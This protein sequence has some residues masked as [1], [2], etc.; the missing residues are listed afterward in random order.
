V[1]GTWP[2]GAVDARLGPNLLQAQQ[3][4][5]IT[6]VDNAG[7]YPGSPYFKIT[8]AGTERA[9]AATADAE[10][11]IVPLFTGESE[12]LWR[13]DQLTDGTYRL[14]PKQL[15]HATQPLALSA[16]G[17]SMPTLERFTAGSDRQRWLLKTP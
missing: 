3:K 2:S 13:I 8:I 4:W 5:S 7:G 16:I 10:L 1:G 17:S 12:Q 6:P 14:M 15:P 11:A 9:L